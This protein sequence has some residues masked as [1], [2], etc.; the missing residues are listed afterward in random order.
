MLLGHQNLLKNQKIVFA[1][2]IST[3]KETRK[4]ATRLIAQ[5]FPITFMILFFLSS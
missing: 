1:V 2:S 5:I 3:I 4:Q